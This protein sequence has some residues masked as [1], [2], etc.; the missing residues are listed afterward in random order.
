MKKNKTKILLASLFALGLIPG[1]I[2]STIAT[3][4][5]Q[6]FAQEN[7]PERHELLFNSYFNKMPNSSGQIQV[8]TSNNN[9]VVFKY[10]DASTSNGWSS[11]LNGGYFF[12]YNPIKGLSSITINY[13]SINN[14]K[15]SISY[16]WNNDAYYFQEEIESNQLYCFGNNH[17]SFFMISNLTGETVDIATLSVKY[18]CVASENLQ[19][20]TRFVHSTSGGKYNINVQALTVSNIY[21]AYE[22]AIGLSD[23]VLDG[24][25]EIVINLPNGNLYLE[26][27]LS[28]SGRR[29]NC[30]PI[31]IK[32]LGTT[33]YGG[34]ELPKGEWHQ[35]YNNGSCYMFVDPNLNKFSVLIVNGERKTL[36]KT[37]QASFTYSH[38]S[39]SI[40]VNK[41]KLN[42][43]SVSG[44]S[45]FISL[46]GWAQSI[47]VVRSVSTNYSHTTHTLNFD[48]NGETIFFD[49][50]PSY[51]PTST[52]SITGYMQDNI[53]FLDE[54]NEWYYDK[55]YGHLYYKPSNPSTINSDSFVIPTL[56]T[57]LDTEGLVSSVTFDNIYFN[58]SNY[59][60][61]L[62][63]GFA[64]IQTSCYYDPE[65]QQNKTISGMIRVNSDKTQFYKCAFFNSSN[66]SIYV[67]SESIDCII[68][69]NAI[70]NSGAGAI[71][72]G[73]PSKVLAGEIPSNT[74]ISYNDIN[75]F[76]L[77]YRGSAGICAYYADK[78]T[79]KNNH[80][81]NGAYSGIA[82]GWGWLSSQS[83]YGHN[84]YRIL[85]NQISKIMNNSLHDGGGIYT[86]GG[87]PSNMPY[88]NE[89]AGNYV[90]I[91]YETNGGI[92]L[93]EG[94][95]YWDVHENIVK[96]ANN[97]STYHGVIMLHD[98]IDALGGTNNS[99]YSNHITDNYYSGDMNGSENRMQLTYKNN[100]GA[101]Y[102]GATLK[103]YNDSRFITFE[104]PI[105][106]NESN[107]KNDVFALSGIST[108]STDQG[109]SFV[110]PSRFSKM[111]NGYSNLSLNAGDLKAS[112][113][114]AESGFTITSGYISNLI[115]Y[116][117][118]TL[119]FTIDAT[120][121][122]SAQAHYA[123]FTTSGTLS[124]DVYYSQVEL[125][126]SIVLPLDKFNV[127]GASCKIQIRDEYGLNLDNNLPARVTII[128][129][130]LSKYP[131][132]LTTTYEDVKLIASYSNE[133]IYKADN[134]SYNWRR[135]LFNGMDVA[136]N[137]G[138]PKVRITITGN[139]H[140]IYVFKTDGTDIDY[141]NKIPVDG[142]SVVINLENTNR[143]I[144]IMTTHE[145]INA[146]GGQDENGDYGGTTENLTISFKFISPSCEDILF[147][148]KTISKY[149]NGIEVNSFSNGSANISFINSRMRLTHS[150]IDEL[151]NKN[152]SI[153]FDIIVPNGSNV[154]KIV[155]CWFGGPN[156]TN[157]TY[158]DIGVFSI[159][160][161]NNK[162][163]VCF[164]RESL[165]NTYDIELVSRDAGGYSGNDI[166]L[167]KATIAN[168][169]VTYN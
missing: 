91:N 105:P 4:H 120:S 113:D 27:T 10:R 3:N 80:V 123:V 72:V 156:N 88:R 78:L 12:N 43:N 139:N 96:V 38:L 121:Y 101:Y 85:N 54:V 169:V 23:N 58:G 68:D 73:H 60:S 99:Q 15:L 145:N 52:T 162:I 154:S 55:T 51:R 40:T 97:G 153:E 165:V 164:S 86:L 2:V 61:P 35:N 134:V 9:N 6:V 64:E 98:P 136:I 100:N 71:V 11:L 135:I 46:E 146:P 125:G 75:T 168:F 104:T 118:K 74:T 57:I 130:S 89:I 102:S 31:R 53:A 82:V 124:W 111:I 26:N 25:D 87:F 22:H 151:N 158:G 161:S 69:N 32:G 92:Y 147:S 62:T 48:H 126:N 8:K 131:P 14:R 106:G 49:R 93:D 150:L 13:S 84:C 152:A 122:N 166:N 41:N 18:T 109:Y 108:T 76:G 67:D 50:T 129:L 7:Y 95:S 34:Y 65:D 45:E 79:I 1:V 19:N 159:D 141:N 107:V 17:P 110:N 133:F 157:V 33:I 132:L 37:N 21:S 127:E 119:S 77:L 63:N 81:T 39:R 94:S 66:S 44:E 138:F 5:S 83:N 112:F 148:S 137:K 28:F 20:L 114:V 144:A 160:Y 42:L 59:S 155:T 117:Y 90:E 167:T 47:G 149:L 29:N 128:G 30:T 163:H 142:G 140:N 56:E 116:G 36:A 115:K 103:D 70:H 143:S 16:G 24:V